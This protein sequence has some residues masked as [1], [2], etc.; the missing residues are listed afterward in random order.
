MSWPDPEGARG[1]KMAKQR[2]RNSPDLIDYDQAGER[3]N[4]SG[5]TVRRLVAAGLLPSVAVT[6]S[7]KHRMIRL[8]DVAAYIEANA[9]TMRPT[10]DKP[11]PMRV[12]ERDFLARVGWDGKERA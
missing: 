1:E 7:G 11:L 8:V 4:V 9:V 2:R 12:S 3:L 10:E 5:A 6:P